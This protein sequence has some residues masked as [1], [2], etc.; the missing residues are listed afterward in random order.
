MKLLVTG[1]CGYKGS[2]LVPLLLADG[3]QVVSVDTQW[4][5]NHLPQHPNLINLQ[6]DIRETDA[7]P[8]R[9]GDHSLGQHR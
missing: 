6:L 1:G 2:V 9:G 5:G 4:F 8:V 7:I 3:H